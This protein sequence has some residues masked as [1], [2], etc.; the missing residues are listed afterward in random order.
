T[1]TRR[2]SPVRP[3]I[4]GS[5]RA[6]VPAPA[7]GARS[8][9]ASPGRSRGLRAPPAGGAWP[10]RRSIT[11]KLVSEAMRQDARRRGAARTIPRSG[12]LEPGGVFVGGFVDFGG[13][14]VGAVAKDL[15]AEVGP[16]LALLRHLRARQALLAA[17][18][19]D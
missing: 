10:L 16:P 8:A 3:R 17:D 12:V 5:R 13:K 18:S 1:C 11:G 4:S 15:F 6:R 14:G 7:G 2:S 19:H 9:C